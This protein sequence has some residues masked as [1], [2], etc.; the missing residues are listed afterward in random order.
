MY[1]L[2]YLFTGQRGKLGPQKPRQTPNRPLLAF[3]S[4]TQ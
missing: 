2:M 4:W 1:V 3:H